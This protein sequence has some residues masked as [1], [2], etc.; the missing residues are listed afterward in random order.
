MVLVNAS[1]KGGGGKTTTSTHV[2]A[3]LIY[4]GEKINVVEI[5]NNNV[6]SV[7]DNSEIITCKSITTNQKELRLALAEA[8][9]DPA[10]NYIIDA[11]GGD[12][13]LAVIREVIALGEEVEFYIPIMPDRKTLHNVKETVEAIGGN[14]PIHL[15]LNNFNRGEREEAFWF[16]FGDEERGFKPN[17][18]I[19]K[20]FKS[21]ISVP[22]SKTIGQAEVYGKTVGDVALA[23][24]RLD[25]AAAKTKARGMGFDEYNKLLSAHA[26]G[27]DA[28]EFL[29]SIQIDKRK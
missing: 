6:S 27:L 3:W 29:D 11:G 23:E 12:D 26:R 7:F 18:G 9:F 10:Q 16:I 21:V 25:F 2:L 8:S 4:K 28:I 5:D 1:T 22:N 17:L 15:I 20:Q 24:K 14:Y 19:L 13:S